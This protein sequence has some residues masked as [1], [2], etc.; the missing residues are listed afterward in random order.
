VKL[1]IFTKFA[2]VTHQKF[3]PGACEWSQ[4]SH[5]PWRFCHG[6]RRR[7]I[8][9]GAAAEGERTVNHRGGLYQLSGQ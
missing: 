5:W 9:K 8:A 2:R 7:G 4:C 3:R 1:F 6:A